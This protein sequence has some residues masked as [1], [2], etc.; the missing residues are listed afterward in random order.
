MKVLVLGASGMLGSMVLDFLIRDNDLNVA[1]TLRNQTEGAVPRGISC[2]QLDA[3]RAGTQE[4]TDLLSGFDWAINAIG[5]IKTHIHD[6]QTDEVQR[7]IRVNSLFPHLLA[8]ASIST[9]CRVLQIA[10][11]CVYAGCQGAYVE[12]DPHDALDVYGKTKSL[13]E[14]MSPGF[15]NLRCSIVGPEQKDRCSLLEWFLGQPKKGAVTGYLNHFWNGVTTLHFAK[16]C[17]G[18]IKQGLPLPGLTHL[19]PSDTLS[20]G[21]LL[22]SFA[23]AFGREDLAINLC[24]VDHP[25]DRS[26]ST[27]D[28]ALNRRI[29]QSA[30][31]HEPPSLDAMIRELASYIHT[32][33]GILQ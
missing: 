1:T 12:K 26:L 9:G 27:L 5:V 19:M 13:G 8:K 23:M 20:K 32:Q 22:R 3:E 25:V 24:M 28:P 15:H 14:V 7:A 10:T 21:E 18:I 2:F 33:K 6:D 17:S 29:W 30:G 11:D 31:Y 16:I 4:V